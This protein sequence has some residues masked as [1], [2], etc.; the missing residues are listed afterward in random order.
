[1]VVTFTMNDDRIKGRASKMISYAKLFGDHEQ[2]T[3]MAIG[4]CSQAEVKLV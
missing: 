4:D 3:R 1:M 2:V